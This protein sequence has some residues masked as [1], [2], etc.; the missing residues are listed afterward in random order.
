MYRYY[1]NSQKS[2]KIDNDT[3]CFPKPLKYQ[4]TEEQIFEERYKLIENTFV[5]F[6]R[7]KYNEIIKFDD[8][9]LEFEKEKKRKR[10]RDDGEKFVADPDIQANLVIRE[11]PG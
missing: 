7:Y 10:V 8:L 5:H 4:Q 11:E 9:D 3:V 2:R 1:K 6:L